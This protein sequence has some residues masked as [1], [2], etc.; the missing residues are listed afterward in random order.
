MKRENIFLSEINQVKS[1]EVSLVPSSY[2]IV[3]DGLGF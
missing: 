3:L 1:K 2:Q